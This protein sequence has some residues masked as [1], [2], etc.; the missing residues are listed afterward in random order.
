MN[1]S[2]SNENIL[3]SAPFVV[4]IVAIL[5]G[6]FLIACFAKIKFAT[7]KRVRTVV[8]P[9]ASLHQ[10]EFDENEINREGNAA[11]VTRISTV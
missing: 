9:V 3:V 5:I 10:D 11:Q 6:F 2:E 4:W 7:D 1:S 8:H